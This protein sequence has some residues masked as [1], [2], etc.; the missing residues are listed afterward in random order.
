MINFMFLFMLL[1]KGQS[2][3]FFFPAHRYLIVLAPL[4]E[5]DYPFPIELV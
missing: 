4:V 5:K 1:T 2:S 3:F